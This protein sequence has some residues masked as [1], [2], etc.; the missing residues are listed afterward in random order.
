M[1]SVFEVMRGLVG[2]WIFLSLAFSFLP[3]TILSLLRA[4]DFRALLSP[5]RIQ[6]AWFSAFWG[7]AGPN[8]RE[9]N[10][11]RIVALLEGRV[12]DGDVV[13]TP[14]HPPIGGVVL[15]IGAGSGLWVNVFS[16][17]SSG[18]AAADNKKSGLRRRVAEGVTKV[19]GIEPNTEVHPAL[20]ERV[21]EAGLEGTY[22]IV[23]AGIE[24]LSDPKV[25]DAKIERG[26]VDCIV[27][28]LCLCSIPEPEKNIKELY[29]YLKKGGRWYVYEH[30][31]V[32]NSRPLQIYQR[33]VNLVWPRAL[34]GCQLCR[35]TGKSI[36]CAGPW[37][38]ID[39]SQPVAEPWYQMVPHILGTY[40]K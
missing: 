5:S 2:P 16:K 1:S 40:T 32:K 4:G 10:N 11:D 25:W 14:V 13:E 6:N 22:E 34:N 12:K 20:R 38:N 8:I 33:V 29:S 30:V 15:E 37:E 39:V 21:R 24:S 7:L 19:Y 31:Q 27:S 3:G 23:P 26:S 17:G 28:I 9:G 35:N 36:K 18:G